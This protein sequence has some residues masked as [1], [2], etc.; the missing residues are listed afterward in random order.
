MKPSILLGA[1]KE[2][3]C[4]RQIY[5]V[6]GSGKTY[7]L[8][9]MIRAAAKDKA[10]PPMWRF[11]IF[12]VKHEG[13][14]GLVEKPFS[15]TADAVKS[16]KDNR[17][18][19][20]HPPIEYSQQELDALINWMFETSMRVEDFGATLILEESS[21]F[22]R[23]TVG[24]IPSS[25]KRLATQGRSL[26]LSMILANQRA[27]SNKWTD[28]QSS[29]ITMFRLA[30]PDGEMMKKRWG[31]DNTA[32]DL[33]L[34]ERQFSFAHYDLIDL[35][36]SYFSPL[37]AP[38]PT[39]DKPLPPLKKKKPPYPKLDVGGVNENTFKRLFN[40]PEKIL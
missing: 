6:S 3:P 30:V 1:N 22:I 18:A 11:I 14:S 26:G 24:G 8:S 23:S 21:T 17:V 31:L 28:T 27:L 39:K 19:V 25:I 37:D 36:L 7:F 16:L 33:K 15:N 38:Q 20:I 2:T 29:S 5:G 35:S 10:F 40:W 32:I 9:R 12:D 34:S 4:V 13:Y